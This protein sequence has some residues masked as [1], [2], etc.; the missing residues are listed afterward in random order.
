MTTDIALDDVIKEAVSVTAG[1]LAYS[2]QAVGASKIGETK[3]MQP[4]LNAALIDLGLATQERKGLHFKHWQGP[5]QIKLGGID[6]AVHRDDGSGYR[7]F[8]ELKWGHPD[9]MILDFYK[10]TTARLSPGADSC[11]LVAGQPLTRWAKT[12]S[13]CELFRTDT[14]ESENVLRRHYRA[15]RGDEKE[16]GKLTRLPAHIHTTLVAD[17]TLPAP[18]DKWAIKAIRVEPDPLDDTDWL[19]TIKNGEIVRAS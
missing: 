19:H 2:A 9:W 1:S 8:L 7:A 4:A 3:F 16:Y 13:V 10:M 17:Q 15:F 12:D 18:L 5:A 11:Y 14:W 6:I